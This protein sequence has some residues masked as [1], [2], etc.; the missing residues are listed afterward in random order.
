MK[1][2]LTVIFV[3]I[4]S[5]LWLSAG[6][7]FF[8]YVD[9]MELSERNKITGV[10]STCETVGQ[11]K[12]ITSPRGVIVPI[13]LDSYVFTL[14][15]SDYIFTIHDP[16][17]DYSVYEKELKKGDTVTVYYNELSKKIDYNVFQL[18]KNGKHIVTIDKFRHNMGFIPWIFIG[19][20]LVF[21][22]AAFRV[23]KSKKK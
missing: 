16:S 11:N 17:Q 3:S 13:H 9:S 4:V 12:M 5:I 14:D 15:K 18:D 8:F 2:T 6:I 10:I 21:A 1:K 7:G 19:L 23:Y 22:W 20:G